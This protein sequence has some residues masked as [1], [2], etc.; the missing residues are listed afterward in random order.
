MRPKDLVYGHQVV[1]LSENEILRRSDGASKPR[2]TF[3]A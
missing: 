2:Q 1:S 3:S